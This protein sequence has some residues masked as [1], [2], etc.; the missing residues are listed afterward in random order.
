VVTST[1]PTHDV[2]DTISRDELIHAMR[3]RR[4]VLIDVLSV[5]SFARFHIPG[6]INIPVADLA[7]RAPHELPEPNGAIVAYCGGP[8]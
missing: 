1:S 2:V 5:D 8:T 3:A 6:A 4:V 7:R